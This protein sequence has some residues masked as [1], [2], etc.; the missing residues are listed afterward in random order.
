M[1]YRSVERTARLIKGK[2]TTVKTN[3]MI[4]LFFISE[5]FGVRSVFVFSGVLLAVVTI[6]AYKNKQLL[7]KKIFIEVRILKRNR[8]TVP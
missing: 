1:G 6:L 2:R 7:V 5:Y 4:H 8:G 3:G